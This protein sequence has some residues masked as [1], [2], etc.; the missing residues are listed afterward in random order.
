MGMRAEYLLVDEQTLDSLMN[1]GSG[2]LFEKLT[3]LEE[4]GRFEQLDIDKLWDALHCSLTGVSAT[5]PIAGNKL[6]EAIVGIHN[7]IE[8][9]EDADFIA[10][11]ENNELPE[12]LAALEAVNFEEISVGFQLQM[13]QENDVY[14]NGIWQDDKSSLIAELQQ[15]FQ[16]LHIFY[17][18]ALVSNCHVL[19]SIL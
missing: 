6:S 16:A 9:E 13:L 15:A 11:I 12:I 8:D 14:P 19:I 5:A 1:L 2:A 18:R 17:K 7:F 4:S 3:E 10:C